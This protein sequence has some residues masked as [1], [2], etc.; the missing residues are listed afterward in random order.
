MES[1]T[2]AWI[3]LMALELLCF[4]ANQGLLAAH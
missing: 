2:S 1:T 3:Y 4:A